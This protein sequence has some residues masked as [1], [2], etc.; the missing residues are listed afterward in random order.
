VAVERVEHDG[1]QPVGLH[2]VFVRAPSALERRTHDAVVVAGRDDPVV[3]RDTAVAIWDAFEVAG[4]VEDVAALLAAR[5]CAPRELVQREI[6]PVV[7]ALWQVGALVEV[8]GPDRP[9]A[10][11]G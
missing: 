3:L 9:R 11:A 7:E 4:S 10:T 5:Y 8:V 1:S 2:A 6:M